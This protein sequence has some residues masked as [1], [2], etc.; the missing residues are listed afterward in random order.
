MTGAIEVML[1]LMVPMMRG[2]KP[3]KRKG[4]VT[5][6]LFNDGG[7]PTRVYSNSMVDTRSN[8]TTILV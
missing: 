4:R 2:G 1:G 7:A 8:A 5:V 3:D 6:V